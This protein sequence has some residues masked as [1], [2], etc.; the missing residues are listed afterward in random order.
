MG[1]R[2][3][4]S[5][6][7]CL[8]GFRDSPA[9]RCTTTLAKYV[10]ARDSGVDR[11]ADNDCAIQSG[12]AVRVPAHPFTLCGLRVTALIIDCVPPVHEVRAGWRNDTG[13]D[14]GAD[15]AHTRPRVARSRIA[16]AT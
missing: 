15:E 2:S 7:R 11:T 12:A 8:H 1:G 9:T 13:P 10:R 6:A 14:V 5:V 4:H 3:E 16:H